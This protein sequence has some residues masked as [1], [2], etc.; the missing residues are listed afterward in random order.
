MNYGALTLF[1]RIIMGLFSQISLYIALPN[2]IKL[3][4][5]KYR[6]FGGIIQLLAIIS[7]AFYH[8]SEV[9]NEPI[10]IE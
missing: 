5:D 7:S 6:K 3:I 9:L 2:A 4:N 10:I 1:E 8:L